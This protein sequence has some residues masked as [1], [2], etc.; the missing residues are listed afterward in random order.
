MDTSTVYMTFCQLKYNI[1]VE[2][3]NNVNGIGLLHAIHQT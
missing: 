1:T 2:E 3:Y